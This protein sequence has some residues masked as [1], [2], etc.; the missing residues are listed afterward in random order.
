ML[1]T[2]NH[3]HFA[4]MSTTPPVPTRTPSSSATTRGEIPRHVTFQRQPSVRRL[5]SR[6]SA[7]Q[8][9]LVAA[10]DRPRPKPADP[11]SRAGQ[12]I[13]M[14][15]VSARETWTSGCSD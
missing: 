10:L 15:A 11:M 3:S 7:S 8:V 14:Q 13:G 2:N 9:D 5:T 6:K 1:S 4:A 12:L